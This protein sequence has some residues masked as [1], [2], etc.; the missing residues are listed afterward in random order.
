LGEVAA[1]N[2]DEIAYA[3]EPQNDYQRRMR[4]GATTLTEHTVPRHSH[5]VTRRMSYLDQGESVMDPEVQSRKHIPRELVPRGFPNSYRRIWWDRPAPT[6]TRNFGTPSSANCIHPSEPRA[7]TTR[8][9][10]RCQSFR[11][12]FRLVGSQSDKRLLVGN[13]VPPLL[14]EALGL[15]L[16]PHLVG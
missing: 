3:C 16:E 5:E 2:G 10:A 8:E 13:S 9:A 12:T 15:A 7:L 14:A 11:D 1:Q 4:A 6:I